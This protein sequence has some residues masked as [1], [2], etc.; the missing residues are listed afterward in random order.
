MTD[1][2]AQAGEETRGGWFIIDVADREEA[3]EPAR[4]LPTPV[5]FDS[6]PSRSVI[7]PS[8]GRQRRWRRPGTP[9]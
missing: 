4:R 8:R 3:V 5:S 2:P 1:G 6:D 7:Q 9:A